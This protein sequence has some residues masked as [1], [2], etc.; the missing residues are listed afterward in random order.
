MKSVLTFLSAALL[1]SLPVQAGPGE[2]TRAYRQALNLY[3]HGMYERARALFEAVDDP[4]AEAYAILCAA[5]VNASDYPDLIQDYESRYPQ[6]VLNSKLH[7]Q[8][9]YNLFDERNFPAAR[10]E[11]ALVDADAL[12]E[13]E[14]SEYLFKSGYCAFAE[15]DYDAARRA[16]TAVEQERRRE[17]LAPANY[18]TGYMA[19]E[20]KHFAEAAEAFSRSATDER[21]RALSQYY[22]LESKFMLRDYGYVTSEGPA[23][24]ELAPD[25]RRARLARLLS[26]AYLVQ[27]DKQKALE[28]FRQQEEAQA[29]APAEG[30]SRS[31]LFHA[32]S[33]LYAV[34]DYAGAVERFTRMGDRGDSLGQVA[35]YKMG[36]AQIRL[37][38]KV[39]AAQAFRDA[40][41][42]DYDPRLQED[43]FFNY[44]KLAFDLNADTAVFREY[45]RRYPSSG[46][47]EQI[48]N[49]MALAAL[50]NRDYAGAVSAYAHIEN[51]DAQQKSNFMKANYLRANQLIAGGS[52][53]DAV[54]CLKAAGFY[55]PRQDRFG[56]LTRYWLAEAYYHSG[57]Y[58]GAEALYNDLYNLSA[59]NGE[60]EGRLLPYNLAYC[61]YGEKKYE[62]AARW[63]DTYI[64][65]RDAHS[66]EDALE[67][68]ADCDFARHN[69]RAAIAS[70]QRVLDE[71]PSPDKI[72]PYYQQA[73]AYGLAGDKSAKVRVLS[74]VKKASSEA[75]MYADAMYELG[76]SLMEAGQNQEALEV[77]GRLRSSTSDNVF[78][79]KALIGQGMACRNMA[80][81]DQALAHYKQVVDLMPGSEFAEDA[82]LAINSIYQTTGQSEKYLEYMETTGFNSGRTPVEKESLY[83]NTAEQVYLA[84]NYA[85]AVQSL[86]RY[87]DDY[88]KGTRQGEAWFYLAESYRN[89]GRKE[90]ACEAYQEVSKRLKEGSFAELS[91]LHY[92]RLSYELERYLEA[93]SGYGK[94]AS[95]AVFADNQAEARTGMMRAAYKAQDY[96]SAITAADAVKAASEGRD[97]LLREADYIKA[98]S[99]LSSSRREEAFEIFTALARQSTTSE[100]AESCYMLVQDAFDKGAFDEVERRVYDFAGKAG[101]QTYW[102]ARAFI[103]LGDSFVERGNLSQAKA[104]FESVQS[105]YI[106]SSADDEIPSTVAQRLERLKTLNP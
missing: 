92:A 96:E 20:E 6:G 62:S 16:F 17:Y 95:I 74:T 41:R 69:Y 75:P 68:R 24:F 90:E 11:F 47:D 43:A 72:Y 105:G 44:A 45:M 66:H 94:L 19:Y 103:V 51:L 23:L 83:F 22:L 101:G 106:A 78:V 93:Y 71:F 87:L 89:L 33:V 77:F 57:N 14:R 60:Q 7:L 36:D 34:Q 102:L 55:L 39:A 80:S 48:Y 82:L 65:S 12:S 64:A 40:A 15:G 99:L 32:G 9:A 104:T 81:Y 54:P 70:Y 63:Y 91:A 30:S 50:E 42:V 13:A 2:R 84:G 38:N 73:L 59:L 29:A 46:R 67:R 52:W 61:Y 85:Q 35:N 10:S 5:R 26:E 21:F 18:M 1:L 3:E 100:G 4:L 28:Y 58:S 8:Y 56:Q 37:K 25:G 31:D 76:R 88:P 98:K 27:G 79:A 53:R 49:Y 86:R 97:A